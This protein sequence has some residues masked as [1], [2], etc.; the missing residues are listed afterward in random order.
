M[1]YELYCLYTSVCNSC[2][3]WSQPKWQLSDVCKT[4]SWIWWCQVF[5]LCL[6]V[7]WLPVYWLCQAE[8]MVV[9]I[10]WLSV[11]SG[12]RRLTV[13]LPTVPHTSGADQWLQYN[14]CGGLHTSFSATTLDVLILPLHSD[15]CSLSLQ[16]SLS[17]FFI[18]CMFFSPSLILHTFSYRNHS[19]VKMLF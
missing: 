4:N 18:F 8:N 9:M 6:W 7:I 3:T 5:V 10:G 13:V 16:K 12:F 19:T 17:F 15:T 2:V 1:S 14:L 11:E